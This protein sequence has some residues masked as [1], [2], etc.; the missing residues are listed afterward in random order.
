MKRILVP[1]DFSK[2]A[3][4]A[5]KFAHEISKAYEAEIVVLHVVELPRNLLWNYPFQDDIIKEMKKQANINYLQWVKKVGSQNTNMEFHAVQNS[6]VPAIN[7][8]IKEEHIDLV[9]MGTQGTSG[10]SEFFI[11]SN[12]EKI[13]RFSKVPVF[14]IKKSVKISSIKNIIFPTELTLHESGLVNKVKELQADLKAHLHIVYVNTPTNFK[15]G[16]EI[17]ALMDDYI[18]HYGFDNFS[19]H[20]VSDMFEQAGINAYAKDVSGALIAMGTHSRKGLSHFFMGSIAED[21]VNHGEWPI[22]TY[23]I[24]K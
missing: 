4:E 7:K 2:I 24:E 18:N 1:T 14:S 10:F 3:Y 8:F 6:V 12:T 17:D 9:V 13:V 5:L 23:S 20:V 16:N 22:W 21:L 11:G 15:I 19:T